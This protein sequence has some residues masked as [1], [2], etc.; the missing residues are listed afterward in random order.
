MNLDHK[1]LW[2]ALAFY[3]P[4]GSVVAAEFQYY[5]EVTICTGACDSF[6]AF[7]VGATV[8]GSVSIDVAPG[9]FFGFF[10][11]DEAS[12]AFEVFNPAA[13]LEAYNGSNP[14]TAN[15]LPIAPGPAELAGTGLPTL[16]GGTT[17]AE[18]NLSSGSILFQYVTPPLNGNGGWMIF[19]LAEGTAEVCLFFATAGCIPD[20]TQALL[21]RGGWLDTDGDGIPDAIDNC[22][23]VSNDDQRDTDGDG[24]GNA[25]DADLNNDCTTNLLDLLLFRAEFLGSD[26]DA[27]FNGDGIV[28]LLDL[29]AL[30]QR[31]LR[32]PGPTFAPNTCPGNTIVYESFGDGVGP[33]SGSWRFDDGGVVANGG[34]LGIGDHALDYS[35]SGP[36]Y[37][38]Q[39]SSSGSFLGDLLSQGVMELTVRARHSGVGDSVDLRALLQSGG[40]W[41]RSTTAVTIANTATGWAT[42][43]F[44]L[45]FGDLASGGPNGLSDAEILANVS[46]IALVHD[47]D[48]TSPGTLA[49]VSSETTVRFDSIR[50]I[51]KLPP[52]T[53]IIDI[54]QDGG[55]E[56]GD[57][58]PDWAAGA[59]GTPLCTVRTCTDLLGG[60]PFEG[61]WFARFAGG[62][63]PQSISQTVTIPASTSAFLKFRLAI[64]D[65]PVDFLSDYGLEVMIDGAPQRVF[66]ETNCTQQPYTEVV[67]NMR[68]V[69]DGAAHTIT[70]SGFSNVGN[71]NYLVDDVRLEVLVPVQ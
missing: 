23:D 67:I 45:G 36:F 62:G 40:D 70:F 32:P 43:T 47:P 31:F 37:L 49:E 58:N 4:T 65:C 5:G 51:G 54:I 7:D 59:N 14:T 18:G 25:C 3:V 15:P 33:T 16:T 34:E 11:I 29:L 64:Q 63:P 66:D 12:A 27:D 35:T 53:T 30:R 60:E 52:D 38:R 50:L 6:E 17:D 19:D 61:E 8:S 71:P 39:F 9:G 13:P 28:N 57:P 20:A 46:L 44:P 24:F 21:A 68:S 26:P 55:F 42:Y 22:R 1:L 2:V 10:D 48:G 56:G 69:A 41:A